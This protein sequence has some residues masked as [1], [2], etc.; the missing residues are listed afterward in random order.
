MNIRRCLRI[1]ERIHLPFEQQVGLA[2]DPQRMVDDSGYAVDVLIV[3][4]ANP[5]SV[6]AVLAQQYRLAASEAASEFDR[7]NPPAAADS[8]LGDA[9][10]TG[11]D[12]SRPQENSAFEQER[13]AARAARKSPGWM[14][15]GR[16]LGHDT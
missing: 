7:Q 15:P 1:A 6:L 8:T 14:K 5:G 2:I 12:A 10:S 9:A 4:E 11:F 16:W 3:C 13:Q